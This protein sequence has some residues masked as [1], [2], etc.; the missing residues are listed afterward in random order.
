[1]FSTSKITNPAIWDEFIKTLITYI[2]PSKPHYYATF[3]GQIITIGKCVYKKRGDLV[4]KLAHDWTFLMAA[5][6]RRDI[7]KEL[8]E[9]LGEFRTR[10]AS[11]ERG[12]QDLIE[13]LIKEG[14]IEIK[15]TI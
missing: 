6:K 4:N 11:D 7:S 12:P 8:F 9:A 3:N 1:M 15:Q 2:R 5:Y 14:I 10:L 13:H